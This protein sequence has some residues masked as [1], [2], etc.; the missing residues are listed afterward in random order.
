MLLCKCEI[1]INKINHNNI[2]IDG[3]SNNFADKMIHTNLSV[4]ANKLDSW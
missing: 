3:I 1:Y 4:S 2:D